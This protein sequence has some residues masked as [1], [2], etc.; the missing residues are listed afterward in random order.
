[1]KK[2]GDNMMKPGIIKRS[3]PNISGGSQSSRVN[4]LKIPITANAHP[5]NS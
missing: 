3:L 4:G 5:G 1:M 2:S